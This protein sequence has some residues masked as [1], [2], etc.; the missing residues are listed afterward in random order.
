MTEREKLLKAKIPCPETGIE[1]KKS[2]CDICSPSCHCGLDVYVKDGTVI[3]VEGS[4]DHPMNQGALC[5]KGAANRQYLYRK[6]R[7]RSP[8]KRSGPKGSGKFQEIS[9]EEAY[10]E[11][12]ANLNRIKGESGANSVA[13]VSGFSKWYR[14]I[15]KRFAYAFGSI[16]YATES[17]CC[18]DSMVMAWE[19]TTGIFSVPDVAHAKVFLGWALNPHYSNHL[20]ARD[21]Q[22]YKE[23]GGKIIIVDPRVTPAVDKFADIHLQLRPGTDGA[24]ALGMAKII[25]DNGWQ[26]QEFIDKYTYG[27]EEYAQY[28]QQFDLDRVSKITGLNPDDIYR[29]TEMFA[30]N[31][32]AAI[33]QSASPVSHHINGYQNYRALIALAGLTGNYDCPGGCF[34]MPF[35][36][37]LQSAGFPTR[38]KEFSAEVKPASS[39]PRISQGH[40]PAWDFFMDEFQ[41]MD[42]TEQ[43]MTEKPYL[44][45]GVFAL[46]LNDRMFPES[47]KVR[48]ALK[49]LDFLV[50]SDLFMTDVARCADI[51][52]PAC[53][54]LERGEYKVYPGGFSMFTKP[55]IPPLYHSKSDVDILCELSKYMD[56]DPMLNQGYEACVDWIIAPTGLTVAELK[57]SDVPV[58]TPSARPPMFGSF[59]EN[60]F[61]TPTGKF[62][63]KSS[64]IEQL[65]KELGYDA[66]PT[67]REPLD[68][69]TE[70]YQ[71]QLMTGARMS[72]TLHS[73]T[74]DV[75]WLRSFRPHPMIDINVEDAKRLGIEEGDL[76]E[77]YN[78]H[79]QVR[80]L[81]NPT[82]CILPGNLQL[83][84]GYRE[85]NANNLIG[86]AHLDPY[87]GFPGYKSAGCN[88][89]KVQEEK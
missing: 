6:D 87:T 27:Y 43:I 21:V 13:F 36:Y 49:K 46:G 70:S 65:P 39:Q 17:S 78:A 66:L 11:I 28:V 80:A 45:R 23:H 30:T 52:L 58:M 31:K 59:L 71:F 4:K 9:W 35:T 72:F 19:T 83:C 68:D 86:A 74:H 79:G 56:L 48:E 10:A 63:F 47:S 76:L 57:K 25:I 77:L 15:F 37:T 1:V 62:E 54:S 20:T 69:E 18:F 61:M 26:D 44:I 29:A 84:H 3:K 16:N 81:A 67:F 32:P 12:S 73:R 38:E 22:M 24:L 5:P 41:M 33:N 8:L 34:P 88:L 7:L 82:D 60:G 89:R 75:P 51:V 55:V 40:Y 2:I 64:R 85:A 42:M 14:P 53:T 50:A